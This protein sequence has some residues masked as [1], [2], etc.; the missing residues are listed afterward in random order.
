METN[1]RLNPASPDTPKG[2]GKDSSERRCILTGEP[3]PR[4]GLIRLALGPEGQVAADWSERL[5]GR[6]AWITADRTLFDTVAAKGRLRGALARAFKGNGF[7]LPDDLGDRIAAGL[8]QRLLARLGLEKRSGTLILG[9]DRVREALAKGKVFAVL[10]A[11]DAR[12]DGSDRIDGMA[13]AVGESLGED[14]PH[15]RVPIARDALSAA[16]GRENVVHMALVDE[17]AATRVLADLDRLAGFCGDKPADDVK[18]AEDWAAGATE[19]ALPLRE[20]H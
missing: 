10:H 11:A 7:S 17:G 3:A 1:D 19:V 5:P 16:L 9:G 2:R 15:R 18:S 14:I 13:R 6:G 20:R 8:Q 4:T 12:P